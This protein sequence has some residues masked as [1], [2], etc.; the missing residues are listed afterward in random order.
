MGARNRGGIGF[1][2]QPARLHRL[3]EF[4]PWNQ[5]RGPIN[6]EKYGL[7]IVVIIYIY[8]YLQPVGLAG[9]WRPRSKRYMEPGENAPKPKTQWALRK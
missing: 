3:A 6:I 4:I 1:S 5:F 9:F 7:W 2:Y 8:I